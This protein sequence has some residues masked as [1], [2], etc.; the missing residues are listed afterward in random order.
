MRIAIDANDD[1]AR[2]GGD[3]RS[4]DAAPS[5]F[6]TLGR[7]GLRAFLEAFEVDAARG[8]HETTQRSD[9]AADWRLVLDPFGNPASAW[10]PATARRHAALVLDVG[11][12]RAQERELSRPDVALR[13]YRTLE[14]LRD[15]D[16]LLTPSSATRDE[17]L[18]LLGLP[19]DAVATI[20]WFASDAFVPADLD[21]PA[22]LEQRLQL[23]SHRINRSYV[24]AA[25]SPGGR[26]PLESVVES[27]LALPRSELESLQLVLLGPLRLDDQNRMRPYLERFDRNDGLIIVREADVAARRTLLQY[28][29]AYVHASEF[30]GD[31]TAILEAMRCGAV[32]IAG[33]N[34][35]QSEALGDAG[36]YV[37]PYNPVDLTAQLRAALGDVR[38]AAGLRSQALARGAAH[39]PREVAANAS[40]AFEARVEASSRGSRTRSDAH[41]RIASAA[42]STTAR[43]ARRRPRIA[44]FSPFSPKISGISV[45]AERLIAELKRDYAIDLYHDAGYIP[46][47][48]LAAPEFA[49]YDHRQFD[50]NDAAFDYHA[51][52]Y[53]MGNSIYH[54][55]LYEHLL[56]RPGVVALHDFRLCAFQL[57]YH[58]TFRNGGLDRFAAELAYDEPGLVGEII[59]RAEEL[60]RGEGGLPVALARRGI[61]LNKRLIERSSGV[62]V[63]SNWCLEQ[64]RA[65]HPALVSKLRVIP[66]GATPVSWSEEARRA[67]RARFEIA[68]EALVFGA[69]GI[70]SQGKMNV[71]TAAAFAPI[72]REL[73]AATLLFAGMEW[74]GGETRRK[75]AE[76]G[77]ERRVRFLGRLSKDD[78]E[79]L[80]GAADVGIGLRRPP[81]DGETSGALLEMLR[82][83][84]PTI[85]NDVGTFGDYPDDVVLKTRWPD[86]GIEG[87]TEALRSLATAPEHRRDL[88]RRAVEH[89]AR[90]HSWRAAADEYGALIERH[91]SSRR[92]AR[93]RLSGRGQ[94]R[95]E[96]SSRRAAS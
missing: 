60:R 48:A 17:C 64:V 46:D 35:A 85:V 20:G 84:L 49:A 86:D 26:I 56:R 73:P 50:R 68:P 41:A 93:S 65:K 6:V 82:A 62:V 83:G 18:R 87:L 70:V 94:T 45:Y 16:L 89:T 25:T 80:I 43:P 2:A 22:G 9:V 27:F 95:G 54:A 74:D 51:V 37:N 30:E 8:G 42:P 7:G 79:A 52:V 59:P 29:A 44:F 57:W 72:A 91:A 61:H 15:F 88:A 81:T 40:A 76:L 3:A 12:F 23:S 92:E 10:T 31:P 14:R 19:A 96:G 66:H 90:R 21:E 53:Q 13:A 47:L 63:H 67:T 78:F 32:V 33:R 69:F 4:R 11:A 55:F 39:G 1:Q 77:L 36:L 5:A 24:L 28:C 58:E 71:E 38:L 75:V 34:S